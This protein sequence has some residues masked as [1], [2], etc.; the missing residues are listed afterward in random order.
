MNQ[1]GVGLVG[2]VGLHEQIAAIS[3]DILPKSSLAIGPRR[4]PTQATPEEKDPP[5]ACRVL[6]D[7]SRAGLVSR[8]DLGPLTRICCLRLPVRSSAMPDHGCAPLPRLTQGHGHAIVLE[9][10]GTLEALFLDAAQDLLM[11][12]QASEDAPALLFGSRRADPHS[13]RGNV[14]PS[15]SLRLPCH[16]RLPAALLRSRLWRKPCSFGAGL[17]PRG[18]L[19]RVQGPTQAEV[20]APLLLRNSPGTLARSCAIDR[21]DD[22]TPQA[23]VAAQGLDMRPA[24]RPAAQVQGEGSQPTKCRHTSVRSLHF[25][26]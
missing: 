1:V 19:G 2:F 24:V 11:A 15:L 20:H 10:E 17:E 3:W 12:Q 5:C 9:H 6:R 22:L 13:S 16:R 18:I 21:L 7:P 14:R 23:E 25:W 8:L 26:L 4:R